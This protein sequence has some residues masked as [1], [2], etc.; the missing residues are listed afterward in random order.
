MSKGR[1]IQS[2]EIGG[3]LLASLARSNGPQ[4]LRD[5]AQDSNL[6]PAQAHAYLSSLCRVGLVEQDR[7]SGHYHLGA[8]SMRLGLARLRTVDLFSRATA[9]AE[10]MAD[11]T[12]LLVIVVVWSP[13]GPAAVQVAGGAALNLGIKRG[14]FFALHHT[15]AGQVFAAWPPNAACNP[16]DP[17]DVALAEVARAR[18]YGFAI[19]NPIPGITAYSA[20]VFDQQDQLALALTIAGRSGALEA[21]DRV[22]VKLRRHA[23]LLSAKAPRRRAPKD[24]AL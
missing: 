9:V 6:A 15:A 8:F 16:V 4:M 3:R 23:K 5:L 2:I 12:G 21:S 13:R 22:L 17:A 19:G 18:G 14:T 10:Q 1:G 24:D 20:P 11:D 7:R